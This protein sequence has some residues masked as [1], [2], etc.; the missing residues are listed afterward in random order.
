MNIWVR[1][2]PRNR[3]RM[4]RQKM[5]R[6]LFITFE[7]LDKAGKSTQ[8]GR[9]RQRLENSGREVVQLREPGG[10][11]LGE[12]VRSLV[13]EFKGGVC[14]LA[15]LLLFAAS[16]AQLVREKVEPALA[17]GRIVLCDRFA[18]ST[19]A[20]Q[21]FARG[22][23]QAVIHRL[24]ALA[25]GGCVPDLTVFLDISVEDSFRRLSAVLSRSAAERDRFET[26]G[27]RFHEQVRA[28]FLHVA[29]HEP[30]R[31]VRFDAVQSPEVIEEQIWQQVLKRLAQRE[32]EK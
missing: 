19:M 12:A 5:K 6:G 29:E 13:M 20:Y 10:T 25:V 24:N 30:Q 9:L 14:D 8:I 31:V 1:P 17:A 21:G 28:G 32:G 2:L 16:R 23:E 7:G 3:N 11:P 26:E 15:E 22:M 4:C 18:D 27:R